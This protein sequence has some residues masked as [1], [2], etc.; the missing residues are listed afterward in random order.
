MIFFSDF[1][2]LVIILCLLLCYCINMMWVLDY[3]GSCCVFISIYLWVCDIFGSCYT[4]LVFLYMYGQVFLF[5][6]FLL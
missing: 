3:Q 1:A 5:L 2:Y 6:G 4:Y